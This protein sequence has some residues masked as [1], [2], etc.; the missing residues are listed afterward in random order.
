MCVQLKLN[1]CWQLDDSSILKF[2][3]NCR[4][5]LEI[6][7][8]KCHLITDA[9]ITKLME[10]GRCLRELRLAECDEISDDAFLS[11]SP[12]R[13]FD[14]LR[15]L[16]LSSCHKLTDRAVERIIDCAPRLRNLVLAKCRLITNTA[17][18]AI[19]KLG[20]NLHFL[21]LGHCVQITDEAVI[22]LVSVCNRIRYID[23]GC[24]VHLTD[25][26]VRRLAMLPKLRRIGL[27]KCHLIT[28][29]SVLALSNSAKRYIHPGSV[30]SP[31]PYV[32]S[33]S[34]LERVHLS[35]CTNLT[36]DVSAN[37]AYVRYHTDILVVYNPSPEQ[38]SSP[39]TSV[40]DWR[41]SLPSR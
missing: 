34:S 4:N 26:T 39:H 38:L 15:I 37:M 23:L 28:N 2:A 40:F 11:L 13:T 17:L 33:H 1:R 3:T 9:P 35:Y 27:V 32:S 41:D 22:K 14:A 29:D 25:A 21:H 5:L 31:G 30:D 8:H 6:D 36:L 20:K 7:L 10:H 12:R 18:A 16:D 24:C 19:S